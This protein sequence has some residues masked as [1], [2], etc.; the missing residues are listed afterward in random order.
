MRGQ[1]SGCCERG[2]GQ[3]VSSV[4]EALLALASDEIRAALHEAKDLRGAFR[5][6]L[7]E[8]RA[9]Q[10][11]QHEKIGALLQAEV[12]AVAEAIHAQAVADLARRVERRAYYQAGLF[13]AIGVTLGASIVALVR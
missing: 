12:R 11:L 2:M 4:E 8:L 7:E 3:S 10:D 6:A 1:S 5:E 9:L 13:L